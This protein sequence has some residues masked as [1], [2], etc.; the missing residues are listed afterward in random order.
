MSSISN[1]ST[2]NMSLTLED[3][4]DMSD[5]NSRTFFS[6]SKK[7]YD[8]EGARTPAC[9]ISEKETKI[10]MEHATA[11]EKAAKK[12][13]K[14]AT[15]L[16]H[17]A[18]LAAAKAAEIESREREKTLKKLAKGIANA[19]CSVLKSKE[20]DSSAP[21]ENSD[22][23]SLLRSS[24]TVGLDRSLSSNSLIGSPQLTL[25]E[26]LASETGVAAFKEFAAEGFV[27]ENVSFVLE[28]RAFDLLE[29][30]SEPWLKRAHEIYDTY[31]KVGSP[32]EVF[33]SLSLSSL[34]FSLSLSLSTFFRLF[35]FCHFRRSVCEE[36]SWQCVN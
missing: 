4:K 9:R 1:S 28:I 11:S 26:V 34:L 10:R 15:K 13:I 7:A 20:H 25:Q 36:M 16:K 21:F 27:L 3:G 30:N 32:Q 6:L 33:S 2:F 8:E 23:L 12:A 17:E 18:E 14:L 24:S 35:F 5:L 19:K 22:S 29:E 31:V